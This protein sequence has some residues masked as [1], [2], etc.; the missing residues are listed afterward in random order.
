MTDEPRP[1]T[2]RDREVYEGIANAE[3]YLLSA[4]G[5]TDSG[6]AL[7][8]MLEAQIVIAKALVWIAD[9]PEA[10]GV[11]ADSPPCGAWIATETYEGYP[12][13]LRWCERRSGPCPFPGTTPTDD[14]PCAVYAGLKP[15]NLAGYGS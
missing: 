9:L 7:T 3:R 5:A 12:R 4:R 8:G 2:L 6:F 15:T 14:R 10:S 11:S 1:E 13:T